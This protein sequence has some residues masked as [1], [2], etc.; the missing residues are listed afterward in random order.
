MTVQ[1]ISARTASS[2][3]PMRARSCSSLP[4]CAMPRAASRRCSAWTAAC[5]CWLRGFSAAAIDSR[6]QSTTSVSSTPWRPPAPSDQYRLFDLGLR[7]E[8]N[9][10]HAEQDVDALLLVVDAPIV[11]V[12]AR[13]SAE[14][15]LESRDMRQRLVETL[16]LGESFAF[17]PARPRRLVRKTV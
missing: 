9:Q 5:T 3:A 15:N 4:E 8:L 11:I 13:Q 1:M 7:R 6:M 10:V 14:L 12:S 17:I 2:S 16:V